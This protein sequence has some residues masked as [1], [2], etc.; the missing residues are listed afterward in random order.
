MNDG[1]RNK[2]NECYSCI[3]K[4]PVSGNAHIKCAKPDPDMR[5]T[6]HGVQNGWFAYPFSFDPVWKEKDCQNYESTQKEGGSQ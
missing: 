1:K 3:H 6:K 2:R 5:G 4:R